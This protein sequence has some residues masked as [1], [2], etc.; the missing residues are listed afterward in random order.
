MPKAREYLRLDI[1]RQDDID[2]DLQASNARAAVIANNA[3]GLVGVYRCVVDACKN[4]QV[5]RY[6]LDIRKEIDI[7]S[8]YRSIKKDDLAL[9]GATGISW[10]EIDAAQD[11][12]IYRLVSERIFGSTHKEVAESSLYDSVVSEICYQIQKIINAFY[13][14]YFVSQIKID[15]IVSL[16]NVKEEE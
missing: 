5:D 3:E 4:I 12:A 15:E 8:A 7:Q 2:E 6:G 9:I 14:L 10:Y 16:L 1:Y 11:G 13:D